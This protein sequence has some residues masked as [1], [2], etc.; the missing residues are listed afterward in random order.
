MSA[1]D[2][3]YAGFTQ[4]SK[5]VGLLALYWTL[6]IVCRLYLVNSAL[7]ASA[8]ANGVFIIVC[9][10]WYMK[11]YWKRDKTEYHIP[12]QK[13]SIGIF[14][15]TFIVM[16]MATQ[17]LSLWYYI[18]TM[19]TGYTAHTVTANELGVWV[20]VAF[21]V[22]C[23]P[24][25][26]ELLFRGV[27]YNILKTPHKKTG[28]AMNWFVASVIVSFLFGAMHGNMVQ[29]LTA[30]MA[31][32]WFAFTYEITRKLWVPI[33]FHV[34]YNTISQF[35]FVQSFIPY[36]SLVLSIILILA[37]ITL[38]LWMVITLDSEHRYIELN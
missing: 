23:A 14:A 15:L 22:L 20:R 27:L 12:F 1:K 9:S 33:L 13:K 31:G 3:F 18:K 16:Y 10:I 6:G 25:A 11:A 32:L 26:E 28:F 36:Q 29:M 30:M 4:T 38:S 5:A 21:Q 19:D 7:V 37:T 35:S 2:K 24:V 8:I 34:L 17:S